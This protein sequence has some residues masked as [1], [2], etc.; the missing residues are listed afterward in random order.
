MSLQACRP[1]F[2]NRI[3]ILL[4][5]L[6]LVSSVL[7]VRAEDGGHAA[8]GD[9]HVV[10]QEEAAYAIPS[11]WQ[12]YF[13][14]H[15][16]SL[17]RGLPRGL[18]TVRGYGGPH[19]RF[20]D[21][22]PCEGR[23]PLR[24]PFHAAE[25]RLGLCDL[26]VGRRASGRSL[27]DLLPEII[28]GGLTAIYQGPWRLRG[29]PEPGF[30]KDLTYWALRLAHERFP[31]AADHVYWQWG[32]E[33]NGLGF[34]PTGIKQKIKETGE[35]R[36]KYF[37]LHSK[38]A[39][40]AEFYLAPAIEVVRQVSLDVYG[41]SDKIKILTGSVANIYNGNSRRWLGDLLGHVVSGD[42]APTLKGRTIGELVDIATVHYPFARPTGQ[43]TMQQIWD[44]HVARGPLEAVWITEEHGRRG[45][46]PVT[47]VDRSLRFIDWV[48]RNG[49]TA[50]QSRLV[51]WGIDK[52]HPG[53][54]GIEAVEWMGRIL[55]GRNLSIVYAPCGG[56]VCAVFSE[57]ADDCA[58]PTLL[59]IYS[60]Q[61]RAVGRLIL[62]G[63]GSCTADGARV[64]ATNF[65]RERRSSRWESVAAY[66]NGELTIP[67]DNIVDGAMLLEVVKEPAVP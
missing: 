10:F 18:R 30:D 29:A 24:G 20:S 4:A 66:S 38:T 34:D 57:Q 21:E 58:R 60:V 52:K 49:L 37:N 3:A 11:E 14:T 67:I 16:A 39:F 65:H 47:V 56:A 27:E 17:Q 22:V 2:L 44:S 8:S 25:L 31:G 19:L 46:G 1:S 35:S 33:I 6:C 48:S 7:G 13:G 9:L 62:H 32:N 43:D 28:S 55:S 59:A 64:R 61:P 41:R 51:W 53:G 12:D 42:E 26:R 54:A 45:K 40:Y 15:Y 36:W 63:A 5:G 50:D 23:A